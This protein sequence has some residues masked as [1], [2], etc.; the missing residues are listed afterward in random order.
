MHTA[1]LE[2]VDVLVERVSGL[3]EDAV[4][5]L[6]IVLDEVSAGA[7]MVLLQDLHRPLPD[8]DERRHRQRVN[9]AFD[10]LSHDDRRG[11][12]FLV[13]GPQFRE[14]FAER[15]AHRNGDVQFLLDARSQVV[16]QLFRRHLEEVD[17]VRDI[18]VRLVHAE[19]FDKV[20]I[21]EI[22]GV[23]LLVKL[24]VQTVVRRHADEVRALLFRLP[25]G[26]G[27]LYAERL[28]LLV[29]GHDD[30]VAA[31]RVS[32]D[33][34][35]HF[36]KLRSQGLFDG[37]KEVVTVAVQYD[38]VFGLVVVH[39]H[40]GHLLPGCKQTFFYGDYTTVVVILKI[41]F[42]FFLFY[43]RITKNNV[44]IF[45]RS[46][47]NEMSKVGKIAKGV[48]IGLVLA[49]ILNIALMAV[50]WF[51]GLRKYYK[52]PKELAAVAA[53]TMEDMESDKVAPKVLEQFASNPETTEAYA[54]GVNQYGDPVFMNP[55]KAWK[56]AKKE[57]KEGRKAGD[58]K[59]HLKHSSKTFYM[60]YIEAAK[61]VDQNDELTD[62]QKKRL[63]EW[64]N[65]LE[66]YKNSFPEKARR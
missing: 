42:F 11:V 33:R 56:A 20:C 64:A 27:R 21:L 58:H 26:L 1:V 18:E 35:G 60:A 51:V 55:K 16:R 5:G 40:R 63:K 10:V 61:T 28:R 12:R 62:L 22:D 48:A 29:L 34:H 66:I 7:D 65:F 2:A 15:N 59:L 38:A 54:L 49:I 57:Y 53:Y 8:E 13:V 47:G 31:L 23:D 30:A 50:I 45:T 25:D 44:S 4:Q 24:M 19:G 17:G 39:R 36:P 14:H 46:E 37:R 43:V 52:P 6:L 9:D 41:V 3:S 32:G